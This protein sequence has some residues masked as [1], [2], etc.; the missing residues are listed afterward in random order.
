MAADS[1]TRLEL[2]PTPADAL[3]DCTAFQIDILLELAAGGPQKGTSI[4]DRLEPR[5]GELNPGRLYPNLRALESAGLIDISE[6]DR[7]TNEHTLTK[8]GRLELAVYADRV[9][10]AVGGAE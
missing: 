7:R 6:R 2:G 8:T 9:S 1:E 3:S 10:A 4:G 5:H